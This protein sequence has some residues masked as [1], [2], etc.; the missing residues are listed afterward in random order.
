MNPLGKPTYDDARVNGVSLGV[1]LSHRGRTFNRHSPKRVEVGSNRFLEFVSESIKLD[2]CARYLK[3]AIFTRLFVDVAG[4]MSPSI[5][6]ASFIFI[7][8][9]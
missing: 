5:F 7:Y 4:Y 6:G 1:D 2:S 8:K 9:S 3:S